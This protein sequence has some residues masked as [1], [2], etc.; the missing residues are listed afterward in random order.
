VDEPRISG[1]VGVMPALVVLLPC[2]TFLV[3]FRWWLDARPRPGAPSDL[4]ERVQQ[5]EAW[6]T[7]NEMGKLR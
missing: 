1:D 3:A 2:V 5:L 6:R 7:R 4:L